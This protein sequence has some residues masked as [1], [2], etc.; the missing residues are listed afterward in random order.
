[1]RALR[2][3]GPYIGLG[4]TLAA[5]V[6]AGLGVGYWL[7]GWLGTQP[8]LLL[9]GGTLGVFAALVHF[10]RSVT[11]LWKPRGDRTR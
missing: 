2:E 7:D 10:F 1:M 8:W 9:G 3:A 5:T 4:I 11:D 6:L